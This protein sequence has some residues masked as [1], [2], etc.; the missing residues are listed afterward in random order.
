[1]IAREDNYYEIINMFLSGYYC[2]CKGVFNSGGRARKWMEGEHERGG[3][4]EGLDGVHHSPIEK[5]MLEV[6]SIILEAKR[7]SVQFF[8]YKKEIVGRI[9]NNYELSELLRILPENERSE[10]KVDLWLCGF[11]AEADTENEIEKLRQLIHKPPLP[12]SQRKIDGL[13]FI[14]EDILNEEGIYGEIT[15]WFLEHYYH[16]CRLK[17]ASGSPWLKDEWEL[18]YAYYQLQ[19]VFTAPLEQ[20][21]LEA[22]LLILDAGRSPLAFQER[23]REKIRKL[24]ECH[25]FMSIAIERLPEIGASELASDLSSLGFWNYKKFSERLESHCL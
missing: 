19:P 25:D 4:Y 6:V 14:V 3:A 11:Y 22:A 7:G 9:L 1:M 8:S 5:L 23:H 15:L 16:Y 24:L 21:I 13:S 20:L 12:L 17:L 18:Y 10:F 2:Y